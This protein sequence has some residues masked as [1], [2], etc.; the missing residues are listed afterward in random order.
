M[1]WLTA[2]KGS[3]GMKKCAFCKHY[4]DPTFE[5]IA[6]KRGMKDVWEYE[7]GVKNRAC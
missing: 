6:P 3:T 7:R 4:F 5:V 2:R 1:T